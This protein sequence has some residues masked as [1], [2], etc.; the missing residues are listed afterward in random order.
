[1]ILSSVSLTVVP[2]A[3]AV[4]AY[5]LSSSLPSGRDPEQRAPEDRAVWAALAAGWLAHAISIAFDTLQ[6][7]GSGMVARFGFAPALSVT[8][9]LV[10]AVYAAES[11]RLGLPTMRKWLAVA[12]ALAVALAWIF[13]GQAHTGS[14]LSSWAPVHWITGFAAYGLVGAALMH[15][16]VLRHAEKQLRAKPAAGKAGPKAAPKVLGMPLLR[17][18]SLTFR[19]VGAGFIMLTLTLLLGFWFTTPWHWTHKSVFS[20]MSWL[21]FAVLLAGR[22]RFGWRGRQAVRWLYAGSLLLLLAYVG[23]R[24]VLEVILHRST[25]V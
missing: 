10:L 1:M 3:L 4:L 12:A 9:W 6:W 7:Q 15:A 17:L 11:H 24:F 13:P 20:V 14:S 19:F 18:E 23:S 22:W 21:V 5:G 8:T 2:S 16:A 25:E